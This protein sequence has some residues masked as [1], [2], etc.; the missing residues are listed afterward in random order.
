MSSLQPIP[1]PEG[2][3]RSRR[4]EPRFQSVGTACITVRGAETFTKYL[5][6]V[7]DVS[8]SGL[9][10]EIGI[11]LQKGFQITV[12]LGGM[13]VLGEVGNLRPWSGGQYRVGVLITLVTKSDRLKLKQ[14]ETEAA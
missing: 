3:W 10:L 8:R 13:M 2:I 6:A 11:P 5:A 1:E 4:S 14:H 9:Q 12:E 7:T